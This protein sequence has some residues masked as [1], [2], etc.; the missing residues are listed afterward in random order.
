M[1][2]VALVCSFYSIFQF[3]HRQSGLGKRTNLSKLIPQLIFFPQKVLQLEGTLKHL[4][5]G[6]DKGFKCCNP[7]LSW[8]PN[9]QTAKANLDF[10][11]QQ[12]QISFN[13]FSNTNLL[14]FNQASIPPS[15]SWYPVYPA[16]KVTC[17]SLIRKEK[18]ISLIIS[19]VLLLSF[20][21]PPSISTGCCL[22]PPSSSMCAYLF[23]T[24]AVLP[25]VIGTYGHRLLLPLVLIQLRKCHLPHVVLAQ[26]KN[27]AKM[28]FYRGCMT[29]LC[30]VTILLVFKES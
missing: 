29:V 23:L 11:R 2:D 12:H 3:C 9:L 21:L 13:F 19:H 1:R 28:L 30:L 17:Y 15:P 4:N 8:E 7:L 27:S 26:W 22:T 5:F 18:N 10:L 25:A 24:A 16:E 6:D 20:H 14:K